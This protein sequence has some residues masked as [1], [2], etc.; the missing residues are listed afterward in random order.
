MRTA[1]VFGSLSFSFLS[2]LVVVALLCSFGLHSVQITHE[3]PGHADH[4][5][6]SSHEEGA[7][8]LMLGEYM[9]LSDKKLFLGLAAVPFLTAGALFILF[10]SWWQLVASLELLYQAHLRKRQES[11]L[12]IFDYLRSYFSDGIL[13]PQPF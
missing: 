10:G 13:H 11:V 2:T 7:P 8:L 1:S 5:G 9:H 4:H 3:H 12:S 6:S